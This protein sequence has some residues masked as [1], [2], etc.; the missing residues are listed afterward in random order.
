MRS[1]PRDEWALLPVSRAMTPLEKLHT[2]TAHESMHRVLEL[3]ATHDVQQIPVL[4]GQALAGLVSRSQ[5]IQL[6]RTRQELGGVP[7][8]LP[9][10]AE[11]PKLEERQRRA[12][13]PHVAAH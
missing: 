4:D 7:P 11:P 8:T 6:I 9:T 1:L 2:V 5:L 12:G 3:M 10:H 13:P